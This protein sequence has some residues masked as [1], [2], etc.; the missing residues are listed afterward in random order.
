MHTCKICE[1]VDESCIYTILTCSNC[2]GKYVVNSK[3]CDI[4]IQNIKEKLNASSNVN[5]LNANKL[6]L[7][8][9]SILASNSNIEAMEL[10]Y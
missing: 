9:S 2:N 7:V 10:Q 1:I 6:Y 3:E 4:A 5:K 8:S